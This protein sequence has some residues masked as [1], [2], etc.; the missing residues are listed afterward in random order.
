MPARLRV[1]AFMNPTARKGMKSIN[2]Q[3]MD[4]IPL[5]RGA[6]QNVHDIIP[7]LV[8]Q[9]FSIP[10][11]RNLPVVLTARKGVMSVVHPAVSEPL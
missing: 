10:I 4:F 3:I 5:V 11:A 2:L 7:F 9:Y 6:L 1:I 8:V